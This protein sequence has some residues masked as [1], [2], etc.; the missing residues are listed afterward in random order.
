M[1]VELHATICFN[2]VTM[3]RVE[4]LRISL[5]KAGYVLAG[6]LGTGNLG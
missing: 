3:A 1:H 5:Q 6:L 4:G 2:D